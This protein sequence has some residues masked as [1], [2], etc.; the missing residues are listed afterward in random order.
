[1][2]RWIITGFFLFSMVLVEGLIS[3]QQKT[4]LT[5]T[6]AAA[7]SDVSIKWENIDGRQVLRV[8]QLEGPNIY[9]QISVLRV[10]NDAYLKFSQDPKGFMS[11]VNGHKVFSKDVIVAG[12]WVSLSSVDQK[13]NPPD[14]VLTIV[15]GKKS[16]MIVSAL[17]QLKQEDPGSDK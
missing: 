6:T 8:W 17:P 3:S 1:M 13:S 14:W 7:L 16:T 11:F 2:K 4:I 10:S 15:H 12:P 9:P 5:G